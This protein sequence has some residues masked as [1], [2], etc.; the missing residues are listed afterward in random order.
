MSRQGI[1]LANFTGGVIHLLGLAVSVVHSL[2]R[3]GLGCSVVYL[4]FLS[5]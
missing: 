5:L 4:T 2:P 1:V 3:T